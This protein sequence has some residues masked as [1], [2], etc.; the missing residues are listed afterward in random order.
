MFFSVLYSAV[1]HEKSPFPRGSLR[2]NLQVFVIVP[3]NPC[4]WTS[5]FSVDNYA[6]WVD[7]MGTWNSE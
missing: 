1:I 2:A 3:F 7:Y 6:N 5:T 4:P